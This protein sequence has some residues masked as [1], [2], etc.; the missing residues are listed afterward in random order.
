MS[1]PVQLKP[2][3]G[4]FNAGVHQMIRFCSALTGQSKGRALQLE[5]IDNTHRPRC[6]ITLCRLVL[7][8][9]AF[10]RIRRECSSVAMPCTPAFWFVIPMAAHAD[11]PCRL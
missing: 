6:R 11:H 3:L 5:P 10:S 1:Y 9:V 8:S 2:K 4:W 7:N